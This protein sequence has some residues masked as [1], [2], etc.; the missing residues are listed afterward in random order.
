MGVFIFFL[1]LGILGMGLMIPLEKML[2][3][4]SDSP[5]PR[6]GITISEI[7][8]SIIS[9]FVLYWILR[10]I[11][12]EFWNPE[13]V[14][15]RKI[16]AKKK[17]EKHYLKIYTENK[18]E[19][20]NFIQNIMPLNRY[21]DNEKWLLLQEVCKENKKNYDIN[22]LESVV[23]FIQ[24]RRDY[25]EFKLQLNSGWQVKTLDNIIAHYVITFE[26]NSL[27]NENKEFFYEYLKYDVGV[28]KVT[29]KKL[30]KR[31]DEYYHFIGNEKKKQAFRK[32]LINEHNA[33]SFSINTVDRMDGLEFEEFLYEL[34]TQMG[35]TAIKTKASNDQGADLLIE[36]FR[37]KTVVQAKRYESNVG[38]RAVQEV[39]SARAH[40]RSDDAMVVTN[41]YFTK[42]AKDLAKSNNVKLVDRDLLQQ[43]INKYY[44]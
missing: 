38:N 36:K 28:K 37:E 22:L 2:D 27:K 39:V 20:N 29:L 23:F 6:Q 35:Y 42:Q 11:R 30:T 33:R 24:E 16:K 21:S 34:F 18:V 40:Y 14:A 5:F 15:E 10:F 43:H 8:F 1:A 7:F 3:F 4:F 41:S 32:D 44:A 12:D 31:I 19:F 13:G 17:K 9:Y 25:E 26:A